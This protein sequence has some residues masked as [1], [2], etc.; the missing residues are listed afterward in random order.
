M[1][2]LGKARYRLKKAARKAAAEADKAAAELGETLQQGV[3][4]VTGNLARLIDML[5]GMT[6]DDICR[7]L[8]TL[9]HGVL[10]EV[11]REL[12]DEVQRL[13]QENQ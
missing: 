5:K 2:E 11:A 8:K 1:S 7:A 13:E 4:A 3:D 12:A 9:R 10:V 6:L